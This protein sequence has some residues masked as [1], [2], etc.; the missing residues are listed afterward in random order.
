MFATVCF[1][2]WDVWCTPPPPTIFNWYKRRE[3]GTRRRYTMFSCTRAECAWC[4]FRDMLQ[5]DKDRH[6]LAFCD[7]TIWVSHE[8]CMRRWQRALGTPNL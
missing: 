1:E 5:Q 7:E 4:N 2:H 6:K 3:P 8:R